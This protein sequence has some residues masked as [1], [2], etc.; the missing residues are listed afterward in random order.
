MKQRLLTLCGLIAVGAAR[1]AAAAQNTE[2]LR[3]TDLIRLLS[4]GT[5]SSAEIATLVQRNCL[6]FTP[7]ARDRDN[8]TALGADSML[9]ARIDACNRRATAVARPPVA[10]P[11]PPPTAPTV[12]P[13]A[14]A[15][16]LR[17]VAVPLTTRISAPVGGT[18]SVGVALKRG[19]AGVP[20]AHLMLRGS[21]R[22]AAPDAEAVTDDRGVALFR[23]A[24]GSTPGTIQLGV[25]SGAGTPALDAAV[26]I[27]LTVTVAAP[28][29]VAVAPARPQRRPSPARTGF[30]AGSGQ[31]GVVGERAPLPMIFEV[32]DSTGAPVVGEPVTL[33]ATNGGLVDASMETDSSGHVHATVVFGGRAGTPTVV[34]ATVG[35]IE[36]QVALY[37][38]AGRPA[39]LVLEQAGVTLGRQLI[40]G[41]EGP[42]V[43]RVLSCDAFG[44]AVPFAGLRAAVGDDHVVR[45]TAVTSDSLGGWVTLRA[46]HAGTTNLVVQG[47]GVR[48]DLSAVVRP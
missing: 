22:G 27:E 23:F 26:T 41:T 46:G 30:V 33:S 5:M 43:V 6:S 48:A 13:P 47:A 28:P 44:N 21:G 2:P 18:A 36:R 31:R 17:L 1:S 9:F 7:T 11:R 35:S 19:S 32:R 40:L 25:V 38:S 8:L 12:K 24:A 4:G 37:P 42:T 39:Q 14:A 16:A 34:K 29:A 20:G 10:T 3:K 15:A 45:V